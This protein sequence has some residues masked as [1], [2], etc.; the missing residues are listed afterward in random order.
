MTESSDLGIGF[1]KLGLVEIWLSEIHVYGETAVKAAAD[2]VGIIVAG[3]A[4]GEGNKT[5][6]T[7]IYGLIEHGWRS[8]SPRT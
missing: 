6:E 1:A 3:G 5:V 7:H 4:D 8:I 2:G